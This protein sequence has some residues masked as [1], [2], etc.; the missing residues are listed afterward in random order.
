MSVQI[1]LVQHS[2]LLRSPP[3]L[4]VHVVITLVLFF[5]LFDVT[6]QTICPTTGL[7]RDCGL[8]SGSLAISSEGDLYDL[9]LAHLH[10]ANPHPF[11]F[12][13]A[14]RTL[15][16]V[17]T[18]IIT[19]HSSNTLS[20]TTRRHLSAR[21]FASWRVMIQRDQSCTKRK[22]FNRICLMKMA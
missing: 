18:R 20:K 8:V 19:R 11:I 6:V 22:G 5:A 16:Q 21:D 17:S 3:W 10:N 13:Q 1:P 15:A 14:P 9:L 2:C 12:D 7:S 4:P